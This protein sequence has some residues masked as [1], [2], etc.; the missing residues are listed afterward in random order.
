MQTYAII[1]KFMG[2]WP[3]KKSLQMW[4]RYH[5]K[6][7][8]DLHLGSKRFFTVVFANIEDSDRVFERGLY[9]FVASGLYIRPWI[10]N[11]VPKRE[12]FTSVPVWVR[13]YC[14]LL[15]YWQT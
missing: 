9:F 1:C 12:T 2:L 14:L 6:G 15:D 5:P 7:S 4:I 13:F 10:M 8:I 11:F 3:T